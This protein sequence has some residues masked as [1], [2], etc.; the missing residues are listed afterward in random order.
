VT[1]KSGETFRGTLWMHDG[2]TLV[3]RSSQQL[4]PGDGEQIEATAVDGEL[5]LLAENVAFLQRP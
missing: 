5:I 3:L 4:T 2:A 1:L